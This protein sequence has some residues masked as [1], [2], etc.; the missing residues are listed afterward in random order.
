M[1]KDFIQ[2]QKAINIIVFD[3]PLSKLFDTFSKS[4]TSLSLSLSLPLVYNFHQTIPRQCTM[5]EQNDRNSE[6]LQHSSVRFRR[7]TR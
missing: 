7:I 4:G 3:I 2:F 5:L 1:L 6:L